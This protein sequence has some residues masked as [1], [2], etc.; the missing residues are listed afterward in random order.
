MAFDHGRLAQPDEGAAGRIRDR[1][2]QKK[3]EEGLGAA[4]HQ[5]GQTEHQ[6]AADDQSTTQRRVAEQQHGRLEQG[7]QDGRRAEEQADLCVVEAEIVAQEGHCH[8][9]DG[10]DQLVEV[11]DE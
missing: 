8:A 11:L 1:E 10:E 2:R 3:D 7:R 6:A 5:Q 9:D 4:D